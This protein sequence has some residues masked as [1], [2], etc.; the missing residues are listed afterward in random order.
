MTAIFHDSHLKVDKFDV[1]GEF[2]SP[3]PR[4]FQQ[5]KDT[6]KVN[7]RLHSPVLLPI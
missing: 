7:G 1:L 4:F 2:D 3:V 6:S 5:E